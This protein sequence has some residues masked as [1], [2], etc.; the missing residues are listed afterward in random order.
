[1]KFIISLLL[2]LLLITSAAAASD[3]DRWLLAGTDSPNNTAWYIDTKTLKVNDNKTVTFWAK[4]L[5]NNP[6]YDIKEIK[7]KYLLAADGMQLTK[8]QEIGYSSHGEIIWNNNVTKT[9][10]VIPGSGPEKLTLCVENFIKEKEAAK[11]KKDSAAKA[12][13]PSKAAP[14]A[15]L[16]SSEAE[17]SEPAEKETAQ[18]NLL[19]D[20]EQDN[21]KP[22]EPA[23]SGKQ[24]HNQPADAERQATT[25]DKQS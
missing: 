8:M 18:I 10:S 12:V 23:A 1:M 15:A 11:E 22:N 6:K 14:P 25:A 20:K 21:S 9:I 24:K 19:Q 5:L 2:S 16:T 13:Q 3:S 4:V 17:T 7:L